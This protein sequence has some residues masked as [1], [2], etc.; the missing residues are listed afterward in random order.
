M[1]ACLATCILLPVLLFG[2]LS[3]LTGCEADSSDQALT[4]EP[5]SAV[6]SGGQSQ[7]FQVSGGYTYTWS[8]SE[9]GSGFLDTYH[10][11]RV[12]YTSTTSA[13]GST[14]V[15]TV[16][17]TIPGSSSEGSNST[18]YQVSATATVIAQ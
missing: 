2:A 6:L 10:G 4:L 18:P 15:I 11:D 12:L 16:T 9:P 17:S 7:E 5:T 1:K 13:T 8:L 14:Q 3:L